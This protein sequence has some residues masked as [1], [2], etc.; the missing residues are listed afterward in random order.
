MANYRGVIESSAS[1]P[2][3]TEN[4]VVHKNTEIHS[5]EFEK[6]CEHKLPLEQQKEA[7]PD[8]AIQDEYEQCSQTGKTVADAVKTESLVNFDSL[9]YEDCQQCE[10]QAQDKIEPV[11]HTGKDRLKSSDPCYEIASKTKASENQFEEATQKGTAQKPADQFFDHTA[12]AIPLAA[13]SVEVIRNAEQID[14]NAEKKAEETLERQTETVAEKNA[15]A[16]D[17]RY[18]DQKSFRILEIQQH[19]LEAQ[20]ESQRENLENICQQAQQQFESMP[21]FGSPEYKIALRNY[22]ELRLRQEQA[23]IALQKTEDSLVDINISRHELY[24]QAYAQKDKILSRAGQLD[25]QAQQQHLES[26]EEIYRKK[27]NTEHVEQIIVDNEAMMESL[28][29]TETGI[30]AMMAAQYAKMWQYATEHRLEQ[31]S[32]HQDPYF[33]EMQREYDRWQ[34]QRKRLEDLRVQAEEDNKRLAELQKQQKEHTSLWQRFGERFREKENPDM[35]GT[36]TAEIDTC[37]E[38]KELRDLGVETV[39]LRECRE[40]FRPQI[41]EGVRDMMDSHPELRQQVREIYC[42][43]MDNDITYAAYGPVDGSQPFG[44]RL[45]LNSSWY[46]REDFSQELELRSQTGWLTPNASPKSLISHEL[47]HGLH[48]DICAR[49]AGVAYGEVPSKE[50]YQ[51]VVEEYMNDRHADMIVDDAC[52][53]QGIEFDTDEFADSLSSYGD[54]SYGEAIAEAVAE[55]RNNPNPRPMA[56]AIYDCLEAYVQRMPVRRKI[57]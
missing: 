45:E 35:A 36:E 13:G 57:Q 17:L 50:L 19:D 6:C 15:S 5:D 23:E 52:R 8:N 14:A 27:S 16:T 22:N 20:L 31:H 10:E 24:D 38:A 34:Q 18:P 21:T 42:Y 29:Q 4:T 30:D 12:A 39:D 3:I 26:D 9:E 47:G 1:R 32:R 41:V 11:G 28:T 46:S 37:P 25:V 48:L 55:V 33:Q 51:E 56:K 54:S 2:E 49:S 40:E 53:E 44:G 7:Y 43:P